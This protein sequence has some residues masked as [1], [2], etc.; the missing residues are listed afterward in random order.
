MGEEATRVALEMCRRHI[1]KDVL[2]A[3]QA[4]GWFRELAAATRRRRIKG[5]SVM[6]TVSIRRANMCRYL[7]KM[8]P[9]MRSCGARERAQLERELDRLQYLAKQLKKKKKD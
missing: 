9:T 3:A 8:I 5:V 2:C 1:T 4:R 6:R 7:R